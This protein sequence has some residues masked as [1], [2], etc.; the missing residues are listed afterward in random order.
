MALTFGAVNARQPTKEVRLPVWIGHK[1][2][3]VS[4][5]VIPGNCE[6]LIGSKLLELFESFFDIKR[7][8]VRYGQRGKWHNILHNRSNHMCIPLVPRTGSHTGEKRAW[9]NSNTE[10][11]PY[12]SSADVYTVEQMKRTFNDSFGKFEE[13]FNGILWQDTMP[14]SYTHLTLPTICSV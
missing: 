7:R 2:C 4:T 3:N 12:S 9:N 14:V 13:K 6:L 8:L 5:R 10:V 11:V 1:Y